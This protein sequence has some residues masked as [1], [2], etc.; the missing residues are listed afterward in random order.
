MRDLQVGKPPS[1]DLANEC[2]CNQETSGVACKRFK[3]SAT[4][5]TGGTLKPEEGNGHGTGMSRKVGGLSD[6]APDGTLTLGGDKPRNNVVAHGDERCGTRGLQ[7][8]EALPQE[9]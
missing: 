1:A 7:A 8:P 2:D 4:R 5:E 3:E 6:L 9:W